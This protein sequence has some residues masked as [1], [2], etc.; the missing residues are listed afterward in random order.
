MKRRNAAGSWGLGIATVLLASSAAWSQEMPAPV[1]AAG[2]A[3]AALLE[4]QLQDAH[5]D[6]ARLKTDLARL[7]E[8]IE[9][10]KK[11][12]KDS[13]TERTRVLLANVQGQL[14]ESHAKNA[15]LRDELQRM[16][17]DLAAARNATGKLAGDVEKAEATAAQRQK[18]IENLLGRLAAAEKQVV[19]LQRSDG[20]PPVGVAV[21]AM[22]KG[23]REEFEAQR[24][25]LEDE[26]AILK[27]QVEDLR[28]K[29]ARTDAELKQTK[30]DFEKLFAADAGD[31]RRQQTA[32]LQRELDLLKATEAQRKDTM[33]GLFRQLAELKAQHAAAGRQIADLKGAVEQAKAAREAAQAGADGLENQKLLLGGQ[34]A[35]LSKVVAGLEAE[36]DALNA[37]LDARADEIR[38]EI[39]KQDALRAEMER[40]ALTDKH[41]KQAMDDLLGKLAD[42]ERQVDALRGRLQTTEEALARVEQE[43]SSQV[44]ALARDNLTLKADVKRLEGDWQAAIKAR[45]ELAAEAGRRDVEI[46]RGLAKLTE[47]EAETTRLRTVDAQRKL[48]MDKLLVDVADTQTR[49]RALTDELD[50]TKRALTEARRRP[51]SAADP[52]ELATLRDKAALL[53]TENEALKRDLAQLED[54]LKLAAATPRDEAAKAWAAKVEALEARLGKLAEERDQLASASRTAQ[55]KADEQGLLVTQLQAKLAAQDDALARPRAPAENDELKELVAATA[56]ERDRYRAEVATQKEKLDQLTAEVARMEAGAREL[57]ALKQQLAE[58]TAERDK[59][60]AT[61]TELQARVDALTLDVTGLRG[62][63]DNYNQEMA[64]TREVWEQEKDTLKQALAAAATERD[65]TK[66]TLDAVV[67]EADGLRAENTRMRADMASLEARKAEIKRDSDLFKEVEQANVLLRERLLTIEA[68]RGKL[69]RELAKLKRATDGFDAK[70]EAEAAKRE[71]L[72]KTLDETKKREDEQRGLIEKLM[73]QAP[74]L[75]RKLVALESEKLEKD[76]KLAEQAATIEAMKTEIERR[77]FRLAKAERVAAVLQG[78]RDEVTRLNEKEK[79]DMHYNMAAVYA[80]EGKFRDAEAEYLHALNLDATD[81][82]VHFN[83]AILYDDELKDTDKA[84]MHYRRYLKL[85]PHGEDADTVRRWLMKIDMRQRAE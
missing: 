6:N 47:L 60:Q 16:D 67:S 61:A 53:A 85:R 64:K 75:E 4:V 63:L 69:D 66:K 70:L 33:D 7:N 11:V 2:S 81:A 40:V 80:R 77:E 21:P 82:D 1:K 31:D 46:Q 28:G 76:G 72:V 45:D 84:A 17:T 54:K 62:K 51:P 38:N 32:A 43:K 41:R 74:D 3:E 18:T 27:G 79:R 12:G 56:I 78:A 14:A 13:D 48:A 68:E 59:Q 37:R 25:N 26:N 8:E 34:V 19:E 55:A 36:R 9:A 57:A 83:L 22:D 15:T 49:N 52:L 71:A 42:A 23:V 44:A 35:D 20:V 5:Q 30:A 39:A 10:L 65:G 73:V 58:A 29:L 24:R 50:A